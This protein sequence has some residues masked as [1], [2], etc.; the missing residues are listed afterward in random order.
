MLDYDREAERY[1]E[2]RGGQV[3]ADAAAAALGVLMGPEVCHVLDVGA[4]TG[5]VSAAVATTQRRD[6]VALDASVGMLGQAA[7][8]LPGRRVCADATSLPFTDGAFDGAF[9]MWLL[10]LVPD[11]TSVV[12]EC[13]RVL[14]PGGCFVT[15]VDMH[16]AH[17]QVDCDVTEVLTRYAE[18]GWHARET[19][20]RQHV[21]AAAEAEGGRY[22]GETTYVGHGR[23]Y[24]PAAIARSV[25]RAWHPVGPLTEEQRAECARELAALPDQKR[26]R[27]DPVYTM[28]AVATD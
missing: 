25:G 19:D 11:S 7:D 9:A 15:S 5:I 10:H 6:V 4:G 14:R 24:A 21:L 17:L 8:R 26:K 16:A 28:L 27:P 13:L 22:A 12:R 23:G 3:R 18:P 2:T 20:A 1:D